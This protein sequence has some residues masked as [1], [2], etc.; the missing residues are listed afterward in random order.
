MAEAYD[1]PETGTVVDVGDG[2]G[3]L[4]VEIL[5]RRPGLGGV[6]FE[7]ASAL[8]D[9]VLGE[10]GDDSRVRAQVG[11]FFGSV[12]PADVHV[13]EYVLHDWTD[14]QCARISRNCRRALNEG[15]RV[16]V[17]D[18]ALPSGN[19]PHFGKLLDLMMMV[20]V[21]GGERTEADF[22]RL[23]DQAGLRLTRALPTDGS[24]SIVEGV[25]RCGARPVRC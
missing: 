4:L 18:A 14:E 1:F 19:E 24:L 15:G 21:P 2:L 10:L 3:G 5:R 11:D 25:P 23:F 13:L 8:P 17:V 12:P 16:V 6:L 22:A 7:L 20:A 9:H